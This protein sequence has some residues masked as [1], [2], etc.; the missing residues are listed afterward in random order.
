[1]TG[2]VLGALLSHWRRRPLQLVLLLVG[3]SLATALWSG[4]QAINAEAR[5]AYADAAGLLGRDRLDRLVA[6]DDAPIPAA[7]FAELRRAGWAVSPVLEGGDGATGLT[8]IGIDPL[9]MPAGGAPVSD[10]QGPG[11]A[12]I[13]APEGLLLVSPYTAERIADA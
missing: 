11:M 8:L 5:A 13:L 12:E 3:L 7:R 9:T 10:G 4:V 6:R 2:V 1:M